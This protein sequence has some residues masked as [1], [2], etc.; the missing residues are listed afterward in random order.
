MDIREIGG[1]N[2]LAPHVDPPLLTHNRAP[3]SATQSPSPAALRPHPASP[4]P[5]PVARPTLF[6]LRSC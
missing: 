5:L 4:S 1:L 6:G 3:R 2:P